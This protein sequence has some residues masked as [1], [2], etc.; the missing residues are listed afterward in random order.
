MIQINSPLN[1]RNKA[2]TVSTGIDPI[3]LLDILFIAFFI[4]LISSKFLFAPGINIDLPKS[5]KVAL[6]GCPTATVLSVS[7]SNMIF[8]EGKM[9]NV[10]NLEA[11]L[12]EFIRN[13]SKPQNITLLAKI[14]QSTDM[15]TFFKICEIAQRSGFSNI[16]VAANTPPSLNETHTSSLPQNTNLL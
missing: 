9:Y 16:Q 3:P 4:S 5:S 13:T 2:K 14:S 8:F 6:S 12:T 15:D 1:L 7:Q 10:D 11:A